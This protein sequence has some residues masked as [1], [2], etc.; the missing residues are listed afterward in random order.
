MN[1]HSA[2]PS[3]VYY[4]TPSIARM[5]TTTRMTSAMYSQSYLCIIPPLKLLLKLAS[6]LVYE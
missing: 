5:T 2:N 4:T 3:T 1:A 6:H